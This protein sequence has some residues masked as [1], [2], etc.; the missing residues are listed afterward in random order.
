METE[1]AR[2]VGL[3]LERAAKLLANADACGG[4]DCEECGPLR[5]RANECR[6]MA[7]ILQCTC[8]GGLAVAEMIHSD[9]CPVRK[10]WWENEVN[11]QAGGFGT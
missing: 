10:W 6:Y 4:R 7:A 8:G 1:T 9:D 2:C 11:S 3:L 5:V